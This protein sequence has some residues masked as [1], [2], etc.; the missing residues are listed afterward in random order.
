[1]YG[2]IFDTIFGS[3]I[4]E[5]DI[6][7]RYIWMC[8]LTI[9][10]KEGFIDASIPSLARRFNVSEEAMSNTIERLLSPDPSSKT[11]DQDGRRIEPIR[12]TYGWHIINYEKY[13]NI[14]DED[15]RRE[16]MREYMKRYRKKDDD[17]N[18]KSLQKTNVNICKPRLANTDTDTDTE[19]KNKER[20]FTPP[21]KERMQ[22]MKV[23]ENVSFTQRE[24]DALK[25]K[26]STEQLEWMYDKLEF[27]LSTTKKKYAGCYGFFKRGSWL[28]EEMEKKFG[29]T[30]KQNVLKCQICGVEGVYLNDDHIC[31]VCENK[32][33]KIQ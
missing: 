8:M 27:Y 11:P 2:K 32:G 21:P 16:Y 5:E 3:S 4:M 15:E 17:V 23:R 24:L 18:K 14:R 29:A 13:R 33:H 9:A 30:H 12:E 1:M 10:D 31:A 7:I 28:L 22:E 25:D 6:E 20:K 26:F 19:R